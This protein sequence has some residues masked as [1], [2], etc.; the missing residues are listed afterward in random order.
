MIYQGSYCVPLHIKVKTTFHTSLL[1]FILK[2]VSYNMEKGKKIKS[3]R[4]FNRK[5]LELKGFLV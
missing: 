1:I 4:L 5:G 3:N 2:Q